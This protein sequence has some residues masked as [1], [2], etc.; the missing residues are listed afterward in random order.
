MSALKKESIKESL[1]VSKLG[2]KISLAG[3]TG[4]VHITLLLLV[5]TFS[6]ALYSGALSNGFVY[7]DMKTVLK[8]NWITDI[9]Y[10]PEI[11]TKSV[12]GFYQ[13]A[14]KSNYYRPLMHLIFMI[15]YHTF[16]LSAWGFHLTNILFHAGSSVLVFLLCSEL[17]KKSGAHTGVFTSFRKGV[18]SPPF[19]GALLFAAHPVNTE[20]VTWVTGITEGSFVFFYLLAFYLYVRQS[21]SAKLLNAGLILSAGAFFLAALCKETA[22]TLPI[23]ILIYDYASSRQSF[24]KLSHVKK[25]LPYLLLS[26]CYFVLRLSALGGFAPIKSHE[27]MSFYQ[28][29]INVLPLFTRYIE[30]LLFPLNLKL[31]Y[32]FHP[33]SSLFSLRG[34]VPLCVS[35]VFI[36]ITFLAFRKNRL[37]FLGLMV[38]VVP[39]LPTFYIA[40][41]EAQPFAERYL[42]LP[43]FGFALIVVFML[44]WV[45]KNG[46]RSAALLTIALFTVIGLYSIKTVERNSVWQSNYTLF[47][48]GV[49]KSPNNVEARYNLGIALMK[50]GRTDEAIDHLET[51]IQNNLTYVSAYHALGENYM[52]KGRLRKAL[53]YYRIAL[54]LKPTAKAHYNLGNVYFKM[55]RL[56]EAIEHYKKA[57]KKKPNIAVI[58][59]N[60]GRAYIRMGQID[61]AIN[62]YKKALKLKPSDAMTRVLLQEAYKMSHSESGIPQAS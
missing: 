61:L 40:G 12:W 30:K 20:S 9:K 31:F 55:N 57:L 6:L 28:Q 36:A 38:I 4:S 54:S 41:I 27:S 11:F 42:Y 22:L 15:N 29:A 52:R 45:Q 46:R 5:I 17:L 19:V 18:I 25:Y 1:A 59:L 3:R 62:A 51:V 24:F 21:D 37:S 43:S 60:L 56:S 58:Y 35:I 10:I 48:D 32:T 16:G 26:A 7:D 53:S 33:I 8:N 50:M 39:L 34:I 2:F 23:L 44:G 49:E 47:A 13:E 14:P